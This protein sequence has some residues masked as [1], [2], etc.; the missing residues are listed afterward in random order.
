MRHLIAL[1]DPATVRGNWGGQEW[2]GIAIVIALAALAYIFR[3]LTTAKNVASQ[4]RG[5]LVMGW[6]KRLSTSKTVSVAWTL[7]VVY[8]LL[9]IML[10]ALE[11]TNA[12]SFFS[13][14]LGKASEI[15]LVFLGGPFAA[16]ILAKISTTNQVANGKVQKSDGSGTANPFDI[17][18]DDAG[19]TDV[20]DTQYTLLNLVAIVAV[21]AIFI[22]QPAL[23]FPAVPAF[24]AAIT[25]GSALVYTTN[26]VT[27]TNPPQLTTVSPS[28]ARVGD[29]VTLGGQNFLPPGATEGELLVTIG[30]GQDQATA[31]V[32]VTDPTQATFTVPAHPGGQ[33]WPQAAQSVTVATPT[34]KFS[35]TPGSLLIV[36]DVPVLKSLGTIA[37]QQGS[38]ITLNGRWFLSPDGTDVPT[39]Y[40][41]DNQ[42]RRTPCNKDPGEEATDNSIRIIIPNLV[43]TGQAS[44]DVN[45]TV[46]RSTS[47]GSGVSNPLKLTVTA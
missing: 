2:L 4:G 6:D 46:E 28:P 21:L 43:P 44:T 7:V 35:G 24:L 37:A 38:S 14:T 19:N 16:A 1:N 41:T 20:Y 47:Y 26:K 33:L 40:A 34:A 12:G 32:T 8:M 18:G 13:S 25:G 9:V 45:I 11:H 15:Y 27:T 36:P 42:N 39:V 22:R 3:R 23:G 10:I 5:G 30:D 31:E 29:K 17:I